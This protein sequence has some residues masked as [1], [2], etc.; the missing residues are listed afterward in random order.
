MKTR[1]VRK[2]MAIYGSTA[3]TAIGVIKLLIET[4]HI[5][6]LERT[7]PVVVT[8][9]LSGVVSAFIFAWF[10]GKEGGQRFQKREI[11]LHI[12]V[13]VVAMFISFRVGSAP[14]RDL[15]VHRLGKSIAVLPF[16]NMSEE[17]DDE[18]FSDGITEDILT[19]LSKISELNVISRTTVM[20]YKDTQKSLRE[21]G[22]ELGVAAILEGSVRHDGNRVRIVS[23]LINAATDKHIWA[24][25]YDRE[26]KDIFAIQS[27]VAQKIGLALKAQLLP[28]EKQLI[29]KQATGNLEAYGYYL[30]GRELYYRLTKED[31]ERAIDFFK[32]AIALDSTYALA[33]AGLADTY[34]QRVQRFNFP[35]QWADS[36]IALSKHAIELDPNIAEP[37]KSLGLAYY[38]REWYREAIK[39][40]ERA[41]SLNPNFASVYANMGELKL[42]TGHQDEAIWLAR[43]AI[44]LSPGR[45]PFYNTLAIAYTEL[46]M[47]SAALRWFEKAIELQPSL[48]QL[49]VGLGE[50]YL[51]ENEIPKAR[52]TLRG[53][54]EKEPDYTLLLETAG[55]IELY[56]GENE[57]A[58][59]LFRKAYDLSEDKTGGLVQL[60]FALAKTGKGNEAEKFLNRS[61]SE[62]QRTIA[63]LS[64]E[65]SSRYELACI[66]AIRNNATE[67]LKWLRES[68]TLGSR[69][70]R[71]T[72]RDPLLE[73]LRGVPEFSRM[74]EELRSRKMKQ[75][76][77]VEEE[78]T[79]QS[80]QR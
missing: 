79:Q 59:I 65:G 23:Q 4:Y 46:E 57:A 66:Y 58:L 25:T 54:I 17:K 67:A 77:R 62:A 43:K 13:I 39:Q 21:I 51:S 30:R 33:F 42:W 35:S 49:Y 20:K 61:Y 68:I 5:D 38:Q 75:R 60:A 3:L 9:L 71:L 11:A 69:S 47:D 76:T 36:S 73:N 26:L 80:A 31:N 16:K 63:A 19:Q 28:E 14:L 27:E 29:E 50:L 78:Q 2:T 70:Y 34:A 72:V 55:K 22:S 44:S 53:A 32:K 41:L 24:E 7:F 1:N 64:E 45:V 37:Y 52:Q 40:Y 15:A 10:H 18:Y 48:R 8:L 6:V 12:V 74:M 56:D